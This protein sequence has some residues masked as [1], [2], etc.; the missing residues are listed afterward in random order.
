MWR[1][2]DPKQS[3][4]FAYSRFLVPYLCDYTGWALWMDGDVLVRADI[5]ELFNLANPK[6]AAQ[7]VK[8]DYTPRTETK[9][10]GQ[11]QSTY[12][13]KNWS[14]V[15][16]LNCS[17]WRDVTPKAVNQLPGS[18]LHQFALFADQ[19][20]G[21]LPKEWNHLVGEYEPR[22]DAK[23]AHFTLGT[24]CFPEYGECEYATEWRRELNDMLAP[25]AA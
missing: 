13:K 2:R 5:K 12:P 7:V 9:F 6:Y 10:F 19:E 15:M 25:E 17:R 3:T 18:S 24:P 11:A 22:G 14:S 23:I 4:D 21:E 16:L 20:I 8:H 1:E